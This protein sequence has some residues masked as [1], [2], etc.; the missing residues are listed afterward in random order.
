MVRLTVNVE[1]TRYWWNEKTGKLQ[2]EQPDEPAH[3]FLVR[4]PTFWEWQSVATAGEVV[5]RYKAAFR[6]GLVDVNR[7]ATPEAIADFIERPP[8][9]AHKL[10]NALY[11][12]IEGAAEGN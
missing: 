3:S 7:D 12:L 11:N 6:L 8:V 2:T 1:P 10:C 5:E 9:A 4:E